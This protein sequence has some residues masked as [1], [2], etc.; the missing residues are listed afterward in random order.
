[1]FAHGRQNIDKPRGESRRL[2]RIHR[3]KKLAA[4]TG[5]RP[6]PSSMRFGF[7]FA[8]RTAAPT[9]IPA[10]ERTEPRP[11]PPSRPGNESGFTETLT[12]SSGDNAY[13]ARISPA[14]LC[15]E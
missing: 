12:Q 2:R 11:M 13:N 6:P 4:I 15:H 1:M 14:V 10:T 9:S 3:A 8:P 5:G 7:L